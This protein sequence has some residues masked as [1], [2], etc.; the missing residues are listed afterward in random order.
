MCAMPLPSVQMTNNNSK[1]MKSL[2][3]VCCN[4]YRMDGNDYTEVLVNKHLVLEQSNAGQE[5]LQQNECYAAPCGY[6]H[7]TDDHECM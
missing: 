6:K 1:C 7:K 2:V 3:L 5:Q 4:S